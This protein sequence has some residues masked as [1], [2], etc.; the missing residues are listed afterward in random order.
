MENFSAKNIF[1]IAD[2]QAA[3]HYI[4]A[5][6]DAFIVSTSYEHYIKAL[7]R[8]VK[9]PYKN[10]YCT[11]VSLDDCAITPQEK[12]HL[13]KIAQEIA[14]MYPIEIPKAAKT[15]ED[16][17]TVDQ[18]VIGRLDEIF[19]I[20]IPKMFIGRSLVD[21]VTVGGQQKAEAIHDIA[22]HLVTELRDVMYVGDSITDVEAFK[23]VRASGGL[24]VSFN[25]NSYALRSAEVAVQSESN[26]VTAAIADLFCKLGK[27]KTLKALS[28]W[29]FVVLKENNVDEALLK[30]LSV[31]HPGG[32]PKVQIVTAENMESLIN[33][34][35]A[36]RKKVR[37]VAIGRLG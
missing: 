13:K 33:E 3:L 18:A 36:F 24:T 10:T 34:S 20:E 17:K 23:L 26:L 8:A 21:V 29:N 30:Q 37:G 7:C 16:F 1:L 22:K 9:F 15:M 25:G 35:S 5:I 19:W 14:Q 12:D 6:A 2:S 4:Q 32:L 27:E 31:V 11:K 28:S